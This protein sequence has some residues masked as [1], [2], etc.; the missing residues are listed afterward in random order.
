MNIMEDIYRKAKSNPQLIAFPEIEE[1]KILWAAKESKDL[2]ICQP[3]L[4]V[5]NQRLKSM[6]TNMILA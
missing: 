4:L 6:Q 1:E 3:V 2:G 5:N